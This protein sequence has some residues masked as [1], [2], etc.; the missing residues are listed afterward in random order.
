MSFY[1]LTLQIHNASLPAHPCYFLSH[2]LYHSSYKTPRIL[3]ILSYWRKLCVKQSNL[4]VFVGDKETVFEN[5]R[6]SCIFSRNN[7][8]DDP[9]NEVFT[10]ET[11]VKYYILMAKG[12][13]SAGHH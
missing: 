6:I 7:S 10:I 5:S 2:N 12:P 11:G 9:E 13:M 3:V 1:L 8:V 4:E